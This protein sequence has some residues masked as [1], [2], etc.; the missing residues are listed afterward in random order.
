[1]FI[2]GGVV[3]A[4]DFYLQQTVEKITKSMGIHLKIISEDE[5]EDIG[6]ESVKIYVRVIEGLKNEV[7]RFDKQI[8]KFPKLKHT[9]LLKKYEDLDPDKF[10]NIVD[11]F[12]S[13]LK[14]PKR[15]IPDEELEKIISELAKLEAEIGNQ[16]ITITKE[17]I[18]NLRPFFREVVDAIREE[19][20]VS[21]E[22]YEELK[23]LESLT[24]ELITKVIEYWVP[25][26]ICCLDLL[27][28]SVILCPHATSS[29]YPYPKRGHNPLEIYTE[30][31]SLVKRFEQLSN[32]TERVLD[33]LPES[34]SE[35]YLRK[36]GNNDLTDGE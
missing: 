3:P 26:I 34:F 4:S 10:S 36:I 18:E 32:I 35:S 30:E 9:T 22:I 6:H 12:E 23:K 21:P 25:T 29:R 19:H 16:K 8:K 1:M 7:K 5:L 20:P 24:P 14:H 11:N 13:Y 28:L 17:E 27:Y 33:R 15:D 31:Y 2:R